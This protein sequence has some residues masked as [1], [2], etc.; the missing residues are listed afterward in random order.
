MGPTELRDTI[1]LTC[2]IV[3]FVF[4]VVGIFG[5]PVIIAAAIQRIW[6]LAY[7]L[8]CLLRSQRERS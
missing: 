5:V 4:C 7:K 3:L 8:Y 1:T 6:Q 2:T